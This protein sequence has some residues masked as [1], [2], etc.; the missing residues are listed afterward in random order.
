MS[1]TQ[2]IKHQAD[3]NYINPMLSNAREMLNPCINKPGHNPNYQV[4]IEGDLCTGK[5][6]PQSEYHNFYGGNTNLS[7]PEQVV[8]TQQFSNN[9]NS[10]FRERQ[11][12]LVQRQANLIDYLNNDNKQFQKSY[13]EYKEGVDKY[14]P[15][16]LL[17]IPVIYR[18]SKPSYPMYVL[19][20]EK[21]EEKVEEEVHND[22]GD[23]IEGFVP[24]D[25][26]SDNGPGEQHVVGCPDEYEFDPISG[27]CKKKVDQGRTHVDVSDYTDICHPNNYDGI[28]NM[29]R[30]MCSTELD[31]D[32]ARLQLST[33]ITDQ[34]SMN[35]IIREFIR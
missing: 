2:N 28:D 10:K 11:M 1:Y 14:K 24:G 8:F 13:E 4:Q 31:V 27:M 32:G 19:P 3:C 7:G 9:Q 26:V 25:F 6:D 34:N 22:K 5:P 21:V 33:R 17:D 15:E 16:T 12:E 20:E 29:G 35:E 30:I 23:V 18:V